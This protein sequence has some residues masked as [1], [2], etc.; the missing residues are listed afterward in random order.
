MRPKS[1]AR[2]LV[3]AERELRVLQTQIDRIRVVDAADK[4]R[5]AGLG[6]VQLALLEHQARQPELRTHMAGDGLEKLPERR[7]GKTFGAVAVHLQR[8]VVDEGDAAGMD[9]VTEIAAAARAE[10]RAADPALVRAEHVF[11]G[12]VAAQEVVCLEIRPRSPCE[13]SSHAG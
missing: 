10:Q 11:I 3:A 5:E 13:C 6:F 1:L 4:G 7:F 8:L 2:L 12:L 9:H